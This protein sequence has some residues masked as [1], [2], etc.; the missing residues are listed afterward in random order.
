LAGS[1][2]QEKGTI[3]L[4]IGTLF[5]SKWLPVANDLRT[6]SVDY[7]RNIYKKVK[8]PEKKT[9][10]PQGHQMEKHA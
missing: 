1:L 2:E 6:I 4:S 3:D 9:H 7:D 8:K 10:N 5:A